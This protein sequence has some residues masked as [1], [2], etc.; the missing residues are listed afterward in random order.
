MDLH[1]QIEAWIAAQK[2]LEQQ[3]EFDELNFSN[4]DLEKLINYSAE[5]LTYAIKAAIAEE[6][7]YAAESLV[8]AALTM[9]PDNIELSNQAIRTASLLGNG[10]L[11]IKRYE[12]IIGFDYRCLTLSGYERFINTLI[13]NKKYKRAQSVLDMAIALYGEHPEFNKRYWERKVSRYLSRS[14]TNISKNDQ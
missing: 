9:Y 12:E 14:Q 1:T 8:N 4:V 5:D 13:I 2:K 11:L 7:I 6:R 10:F 3:A